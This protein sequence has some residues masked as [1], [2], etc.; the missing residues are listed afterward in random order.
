MTHRNY[1]LTDNKIIRKDGGT[2]HR[3][4]ATVDL[5]HHKVAAGDKGGFIEHTGNLSG[6]AWI[7][8]S[9]HVSGK[10]QVLERARVEGFAVVHGN[11]TIEGEARVH[12]S[13]QVYGHAVISGKAQITG[14]AVVGGDTAVYGHA[15]V[16]GRA[17]VRDSA[18]VYDRARVHG[19]ARIVG[20]SRVCQDAIIYG[21]ACIARYSRI[22]G[23]A[24][25][26][27]NAHTHGNVEIQGMCEIGGTADISTPEQLQTYVFSTTPPGFVQY[28]DYIDEKTFGKFQVKTGLPNNVFQIT[29]PNV[30]PRLIKEF[31]TPAIEQFGL[32]QYIPDEWEGDTLTIKHL[33]KVSVLL[34]DWGGHVLQNIHDGDSEEIR[35]L[36]EYL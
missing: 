13:A 11:A 33:P 17:S 9:A 34:M 35:S 10:A 23:R 15:Q 30:H 4:Q 16:F 36:R 8:G 25:V 29:I 26:Y 18:Q 1:R 19:Y 27:S 7:A 22:Y 12:H 32:T 14:E 31:L 5:P 24:Q 28:M 20:N 6:A 2:L 21:K 3:I